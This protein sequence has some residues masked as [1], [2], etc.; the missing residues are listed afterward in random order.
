MKGNPSIILISICVLALFTVCSCA[1]DKQQEWTGDTFVYECDN[2]YVFVARIEGE[3][4][5]LFLPGSTVQLPH[6]RSG[7]GAKYSD[8]SVTF[9]SRGEEAMLE[10]EGEEKRTCR[11]N[12]AKAIWEHAKLNGVDFRAIGNE[13]GW[14]LEISAGLESIVFVTDY[15]EN[16]Y[17]FPFVEPTVNNEA[18][19]AVYSVSTGDHEFEILLVGGDC[20]DTMSGEEFETA[21]K[22]ILDG[23]KYYGC[24]RALH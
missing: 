19:T 22:V 11:N 20:R 13:P 14:H 15:G 5:W 9:W 8:G 6:V 23:K 4:A 10:V 21:V 17:E 2:D 1:N 16:R 24:G 18:G 12:R 7:S 3:T